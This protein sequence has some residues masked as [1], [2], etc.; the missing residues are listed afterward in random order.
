MTNSHYR[1][2]IVRIKL[3]VGIS[4]V[5]NQ[6]IQKETLKERIVNYSNLWLYHL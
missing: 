2:K 4:I 5:H 3:A 1:P 6:E